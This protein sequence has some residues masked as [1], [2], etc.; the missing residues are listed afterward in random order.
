MSDTV[1]ITRHEYEAL[2]ADAERYLH[3]RNNDM[4]LEYSDYISNA[5]NDVE[6]PSLDETIDQARKA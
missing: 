3:M 5:I 1:T 4:T 2:K 6:Q